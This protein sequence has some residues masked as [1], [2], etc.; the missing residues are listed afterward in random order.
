MN[1][2]YWL[3]IAPLLKIDKIIYYCLLKLN[4]V[5]GIIVGGMDTNVNDF[6]A[7]ISVM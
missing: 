2:S 4:L 3:A 5:S 6:S 1:M 7:V